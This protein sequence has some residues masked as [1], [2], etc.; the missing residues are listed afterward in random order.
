MSAITLNWLALQIVRAAA[1][2]FESEK[3][4]TSCIPKQKEV[5]CKSDTKIVEL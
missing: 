3:K 4:R 2:F 1:S 5:D